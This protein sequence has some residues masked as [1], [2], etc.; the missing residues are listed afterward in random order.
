MFHHPSIFHHLPSSMHDDKGKEMNEPFGDKADRQ[1]KFIFIYIARL[2][3][4]CHFF[5]VSSLSSVLSTTSLQAYE[6]TNTL[7]SLLGAAATCGCGFH[8]KA[9]YIP[10]SFFEFHTHIYNTSK[11]QAQPNLLHFSRSLFHSSLSPPFPFLF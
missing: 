5:L 8:I 2:F 9:I 7:C 10:F 4:H 6:S 1:G 3:P 11:L